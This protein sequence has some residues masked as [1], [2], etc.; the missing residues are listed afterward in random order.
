MCPDAMINTTTI[1][2]TLQLNS[3]RV[4]KSRTVTEKLDSDGNVVE[5]TTVEEWE[6]I[7]YSHPYT[8][9]EPYIAPHPCDP[10]YR[11][12]WARGGTIQQHSQT[13]N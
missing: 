2:G 7:K 8:I 11:V 9:N 10:P 12:T 5:R 1:A 4:L 13:F 6:N 3:N